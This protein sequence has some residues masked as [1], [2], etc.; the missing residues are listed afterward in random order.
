VNEEDNE[1]KGSQSVTD[2][3]VPGMQSG[4][5]DKDKSSKGN[6][7]TSSEMTMII[8]MMQRLLLETNQQILQEMKEGQK[9]AQEAQKQAQEKT[10]QQFEEIKEG[11]KQAQEKQTRNSRN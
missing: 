4:S 8:N 11:Q 10:G 1:A 5:S 3:E 7:I 6:K 2:V 9:Q